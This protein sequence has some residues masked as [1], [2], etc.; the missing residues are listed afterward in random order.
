[1]KRGQHI[2]KI[3]SRVFG[4]VAAI[5]MC[6][7]V[8]ANDSN[9]NWYNFV[10]CC[11]VLFLVSSTLALLIKDPHAFLETLFALC[12]IV[13]AIVY[14]ILSDIYRLLKSSHDRKVRCKTYKETY[15][16]SVRS[17]RKAFDIDDDC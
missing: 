10:S 4:I 13:F 2:Q 15:K 14:D 3:V 16:D 7:V 5:C 9:D 11:F 1:M 17:Y 8:F 12:V 6:G